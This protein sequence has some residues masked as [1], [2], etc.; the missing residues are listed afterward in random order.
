MDLLTIPRRTHAFAT[1]VTHLALNLAVVA[2][3]VVD[4]VWRHSDYDTRLRVGGG[5]LALSIAA[6]VIL[7]VSGWLGGTLSYHFGVR[8]A[9]E[10]TQAHDGFAR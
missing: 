5:Q 1:G 10:E 3:F 8:V 2:L 7:A 6:V 9:D 4:F